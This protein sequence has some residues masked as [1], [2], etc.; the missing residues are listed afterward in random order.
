MKTVNI[1]EKLALF[2]EHWSPKI[3]GEVAGCHVKLV[4]F[5]GEFVW[6]SHPDEDEMFLVVEGE[7]DMHLRD[8]VLSVKQGEFVIVPKG[9][10]HKPVADREV[11]VMLIEPVSTVNTGDVESDRR[12]VPERI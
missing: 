1:A 3:V 11:K 4:K 12:V 8:G 6:H 2:A 7:F 9:V 5:I 10:E